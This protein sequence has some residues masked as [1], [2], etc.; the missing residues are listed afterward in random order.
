MAHA[1]LACILVLRFSYVT[2]EIHPKE[3]CDRQ[4]WHCSVVVQHSFCFL[5]LPRRVRGHRVLGLLDILELEN[6]LVSKCRGRL[7]GW[8]TSSTSHAV[9]KV[10]VFVLCWRFVVSCQFGLKSLEVLES[11]VTLPF[12]P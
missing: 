8:H 3:R 9:S 10:K 4:R 5:N 1:L 6:F 7:R 2:C 12:Y 11:W